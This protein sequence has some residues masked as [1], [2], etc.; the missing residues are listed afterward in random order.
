LQIFWQE[1]IKEYEKENIET[2]ITTDDTTDES[3]TVKIPF[4]DLSENLQPDV[5]KENT[6]FNLCYD[7]FHELENKSYANLFYKCDEKNAKQPMDL[8]TIKSKLE[9]NQYMRSEEFEQDIHLM[10]HNCYTYND[11]KS[12]IYH[13][14]EALESVFNKVWNEKLNLQNR[15]TRELKRVRDNDTDEDTSKLLYNI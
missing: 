9:N 6:E 4:R 12:E 5:P 3:L 14:G 15:E 1:I 10:F 11:A 7:I 2:A 13:L 8:I